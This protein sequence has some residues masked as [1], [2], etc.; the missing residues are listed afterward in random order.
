MI[1]LKLHTKCTVDGNLP[2]IFLEMDDFDDL[3][4]QVGRYPI[5]PIP[6]TCMLVGFSTL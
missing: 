2:S 1:G 5:F 6:E 4:G 3:Q